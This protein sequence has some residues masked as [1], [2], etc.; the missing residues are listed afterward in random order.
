[1]NA[2]IRNTKKKKKRNTNEIRS[3]LVL[4]SVDGTNLATSN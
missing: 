3:S 2:V 1:M 4:K